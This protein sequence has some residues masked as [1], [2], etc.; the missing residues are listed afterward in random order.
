MNH[1][2]ECTVGC[3][4][5]VYVFEDELIRNVVMPCQHL[6]RQVTAEQYETQ[7]VNQ[8]GCH[9]T[10][11]SSATAAQAQV[12]TSFGTLAKIDIERMAQWSRWLQRLVRPLVLR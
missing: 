6:K 4:K 5:C 11:I 3:P 8:D 10:R 2:N 7:E 9:L 12:A 1:V